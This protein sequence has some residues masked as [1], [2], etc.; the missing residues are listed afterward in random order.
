MLSLAFIN[1]SIR[2]Y[3]LEID[4]FRQPRKCTYRLADIL[5]IGLCTY[6][7]NR[8]DYQDMALF[9]QTRGHLLPQVIDLSTGIPAHDTFNRVFQMLDPE[10]FRKCLKHHGKTLLDVLADKQICLDGKKLRGVSPHSKGTDS[11]HIV[12]AWVSENR[13]CIGQ[14]RVDTKSNEIDVLVP[15]IKSLDVTD[16]VVSVDA[17]GCQTDVAQQIITQQGHYLLALKSNQEGLWE[18]VVC[19][20]KANR[21]RVADE[22]WTYARDRSEQ[23]RCWILSASTSI[24]KRFL[25]HWPGLQMLIKIEARRTVGG[26]TRQETRYYISDESEDNPLY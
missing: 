14:R 25:E 6:L 2:D 19:A 12:N 11:L 7:S 5:L 1:Q 3:F 23:R 9:A 10:V 17:I 22:P 13:L 18:E 8:Q 26:R 20:F 15:L 21:A 4:D 16:A 24:D